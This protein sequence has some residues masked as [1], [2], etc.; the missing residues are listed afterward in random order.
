MTATGTNRA[1]ATKK[2]PKLLVEA[3]VQD[4]KTNFWFYVEKTLRTNPKG[5]LPNGQSCSLYPEHTTNYSWRTTRTLEGCD[6]IE[7]EPD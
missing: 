7:S 2:T 3:G 1:P 6:F 4:A 5:V